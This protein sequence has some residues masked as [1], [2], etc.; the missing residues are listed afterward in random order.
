VVQIRSPEKWIKAPHYERSPATPIGSIEFAGRQTRA[1]SRWSIL[2]V[3]ALTRLP[4]NRCNTVIAKC[5]GS[6]FRHPP[7][8]GCRTPGI[9]TTS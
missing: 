1:G 3:P 7:V 2:A 5:I 9:P 4:F 8:S 6:G